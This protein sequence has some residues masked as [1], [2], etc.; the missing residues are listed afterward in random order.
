MQLAD[1]Q[2]LA[3]LARLDISEAEAQELLNDLKAI[4]IYVDQVTSVTVSGTDVDIPD[5]RN[6]ARDDDVTNPGGTFTADILANAPS[7]Q[8]GYLKVNKIL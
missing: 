4:L 2:H 1:I 5:H 8:D 7:T 3:V 6:V